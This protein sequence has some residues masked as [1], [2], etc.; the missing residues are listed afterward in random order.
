MLNNAKKAPSEINQLTIIGVGLIGGSFALALK[1]TGGVKNV[2]GFGQNEANLQTAVKLNVIDSYCL[3]L[4]EAV[5]NADLVMLAVPI[6]AMQSIMMEMKPYLSPHTIVTDVGSAKMSVIRAAKA[7]FGELPANFV[8]GHP[9]AGKE[10]SGVSAADAALYQRH[11]VILTPTVET[12]RDAVDVVKK[13]WL[14]TGAIV[15]EMSPETHDEVLAAT[16][17]LPHIL[18]FGLVDMLNEQPTLG[19]VFQYTA[20]GFRDFTRIASSDATMWRD[21][22]LNNSDAVLKWLDNYQEAL[23]HL[24]QL[25]KTQDSDALY[26]L[27]ASAKSARDAHIVNKTALAADL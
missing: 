23:S 17:H 2:V 7:A 5:Q 11:R 20:G 14:A 16:S 6:G 4:K 12:S 8:A 24:S 1:Q 3:S 22:A 10:K 19:N 25:I 13:L 21:I 18:A 27:F 15:S 9:I 26:K